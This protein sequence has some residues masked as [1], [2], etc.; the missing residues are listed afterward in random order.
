MSANHLQSSR[1][2]PPAILTLLR[3]RGP[4]PGALLGDGR[5]QFVVIGTRQDS[6]ASARAKARR[7]IGRFVRER[8]DRSSRELRWLA[9]NHRRYVG[10]WIALRGDVL[11]AVSRTAREVFAAVAG[12]REVPLVMRIREDEDAPF[13]GW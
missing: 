12:E 3:S 1:Q 8:D 9:E 7:R 4:T 13:A 11:L 6:L 2:Q 10:Q 5:I